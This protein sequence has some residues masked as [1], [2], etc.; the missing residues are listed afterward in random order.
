MKASSLNALRTGA[1]LLVFSVIGTALLAS[2]FK[3]TRPAIEHNEQEAKLALIRQVLPPAM[4]DNNLLSEA[5]SLPAD[6]LLGTRKPSSAWI[7]RKQGKPS[8]LVLEAIA[9]DGYSGEI[10]LLIGIAA[11]GEVTGVRVTAHKE[12][13]GL[14]DYIEIAKSRWIEQFM[15]KSLATPPESKWKVRKDGGNFDSVAGA[16]ITPRAVVKAVKS[17]LGYFVRHQAELLAASPGG[18]S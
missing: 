13:P 4:F 6:D 18:P 2:T 12:T 14:G 3:A 15:G 16:T 10:A 8:G 7:A 5:R 1:V 17:A 9:P 11:S